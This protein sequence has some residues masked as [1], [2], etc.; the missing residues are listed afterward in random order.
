M[1]NK[2]SLLLSLILSLVFGSVS[3]FASNLTER[4]VYGILSDNFTGA[5][6]TTGQDIDNI[7]FYTWA[8][9]NVCPKNSTQTYASSG[10]EAKEGKNFIKYL[11]RQK[12][13]STDDPGSWSGFGY[14]F[15]G[16]DNVKKIS[17]N[18]SRFKYLDF[19]IKA[20]D[21]NIGELK[22]GMEQYNG[23]KALVSMS[24]YVDSS[25]TT[26]WQHVVINIT[27]LNLDLTAIA[28]PFEVICDDLTK[29]TTFYIDNLVLRTGESSAN[30]NV[31]LKKVDDMYGAPENPTEISWLS[32]SGWQAAAQYIEINADKYSYAWTVRMYVKN[33]GS[34]RNGLWAPGNDGNDYVIPMCFRV[35]N[36]Y[37]KN[38]IESPIGEQSYLI[39]QSNGEG[40]NLYDRG[41][42]P[43]SDPGFYPWLWMKEYSDIDFTK[44]SDIDD[45]TVWDSSKGYHAALPF[46]I[47]GDPNRPSDGFAE[48]TGVNKIL[49]VYLGAGF[50]GA[51]GGIDYTATVVVDVNYE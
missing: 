41:V 47:D 40:H 13:S 44:Q 15:V 1:L 45:I 34:G 50:G 51:A 36:G 12:G 29:Y 37:L 17:V 46:F 42:N 10:V 5:M 26:D 48:F 21:G 23:T 8:A 20:E 31:T 11:C 39:G 14:A 7:C 33:N 3:V 43:N 9:T 24:D 35:Y 49:R 30:F 2:K 32:Y 4:N 22:V 38:V 28:L 19:W 27:N 18:V 6:Q 25:N 16:S